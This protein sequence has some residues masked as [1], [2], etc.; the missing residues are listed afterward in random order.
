MR[1]VWFLLSDAR[2]VRCCLAA[3]YWAIVV[4]LRSTR[5]V[6]FSWGLG[7]VTALVNTVC[8][9][10]SCY[11]RSW[12]GTHVDHV[13][14]IK[15]SMST[16]TWCFWVMRQF[17]IG[18]IVDRRCLAVM[19]Y[20]NYDAWQDGM[21]IKRVRSGCR[22]MKVVLVCVQSLVCWKSV[23]GT[24]V[25]IS[26]QNPRILSVQSLEAHHRITACSMM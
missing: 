18:V 12:E 23:E 2:I 20:G 10:H 8:S 16:S 15:W 22:R 3:D 21:D 14:F 4:V 6:T 7:E 5:G 25:L 11:C 13:I 26:R 1:T 19:R 9:G 24:V 17:R